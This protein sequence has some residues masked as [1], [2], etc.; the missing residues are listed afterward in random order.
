MQSQVTIPFAR[1]NRR[2]FLFGAIGSAV[3]ALSLT[4]KPASAAETVISTP[5][6][7]VAAKAGNIILVDIRTPAEWKQTGIAEGAIAL[8][9]TDK[10]FLESLNKLRATY[11]DKPIALICRTGNRS[12]GVF[13]YLNKRGFADLMDVSEGMAG[14]PNGKGWIPRGLPTYAGNKAEIETR[15]NVVFKP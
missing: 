14:G 11:P 12:G 8:D 10:S 13:D 6:A 1:A 4:A 7:Y 15:L 2:G 3:V 9:M 5:D